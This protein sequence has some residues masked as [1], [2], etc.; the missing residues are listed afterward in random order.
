LL[1]KSLCRDDYPAGTTGSPW[2]VITAT[3]RHEIETT[4]GIRLGLVTLLLVGSAATLV[5]V[6]GVV[7]A[8]VS[9]LP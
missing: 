8:L 9:M 4:F 2:Y 1:G 3:D 5:V 7:W 6:F